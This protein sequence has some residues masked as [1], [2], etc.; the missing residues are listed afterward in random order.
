MLA[1]D[2]ALIVGWE[3]GKF[4]GTSCV[5]S[6]TSLF[7]RIGVPFSQTAYKTIIFLREY[8][9]SQCST[10]CLTKTWFKIDV[11]LD[12]INAVQ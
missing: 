7:C 9:I 6:G 11:S 3:G 12:Y 10:S 4:P 8:C 1:I 2:R 5:F